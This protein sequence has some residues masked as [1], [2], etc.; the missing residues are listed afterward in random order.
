MFIDPI[1]TSTFN[2]APSVSAAIL[3]VSL[4]VW[5]QIQFRIFGGAL[6]NHMKEDEKNFTELKALTTSS[7]GELKNLTISGISAQNQLATS[8]ARMADAV[9]SN[10]DAICR[11]TEQQTQQLDILR[12][13]SSDTKVMLSNQTAAQANLQRLLER[14]IDKASL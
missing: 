11:L 14:V 5:S 12:E 13:M 9:K 10:G 2:L 4:F 3:C 1:T 6:K 8:I 7:T